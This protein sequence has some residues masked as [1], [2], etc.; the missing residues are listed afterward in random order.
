MAVYQLRPAAP[1][2]AEILFRIHMASMGDY[3]A[4]AFGSWEEDFA[5]EQH[6]NWLR[7]GRAQAVMMGDQVIGALD[8][9][10]QPDSAVLSRI[11]I[12]PEFQGRGVGSAIVRDLL[13]RC[14]QRRVPARLQVFAHNPAHRL[15]RRLGFRDQGRDGPSIMMQW[16]PPNDMSS[17]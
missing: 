5:R 6:R 2:D 1:D 11:E 3:L 8:I 7:G 9:D 14:A 12:D 10:W 13:S 4:Q 15:Y 16:D 17:S